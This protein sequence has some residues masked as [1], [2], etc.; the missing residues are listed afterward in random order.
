MFVIKGGWKQEMMGV[1]F[2]PKHLH[3]QKTSSVNNDKQTSFHLL[4]HYL[5]LLVVQC[6]VSPCAWSPLYID[7]DV[8]ALNGVW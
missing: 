1:M 3:C 7:V 4:L 5:S 6:W 8:D 2:S